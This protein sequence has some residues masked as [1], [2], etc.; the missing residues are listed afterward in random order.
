[1]FVRQLV[2]VSNQRE[3][4]LRPLPLGRAQVLQVSGLRV[5]LSLHRLRRMHTWFYYFLAQRLCVFYGLEA[6]QQ[7]SCHTYMHD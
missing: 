4:R 2:A 6:M 1:M 3:V 7:V 5:S